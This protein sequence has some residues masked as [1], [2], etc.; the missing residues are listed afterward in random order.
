M[1]GEANR[2]VFIAEDDEGVLDLVLTRLGVAGYQTTHARDGLRALNEIRATRPAAVILD[3]GLPGMDGFDV[4]KALRAR[5]A[6]QAIPVLVLTARNTPD[7]V[8]RAIR[9]GAQDYVAKP[10]DDLHLLARLGR[11]LRKGA[12]GAA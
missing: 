12:P 11:I 10:F 8:Q 9:L 6:T 1:A 2:R 3:L 5:E 4:L 7:D